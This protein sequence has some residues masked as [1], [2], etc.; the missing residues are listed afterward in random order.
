MR[1]KVVARAITAL[2]VSISA[3]RHLRDWRKQEGE[4]K[5]KQGR[6]RRRLG[7]LPFAT[8]RCCG[9]N[10]AYGRHTICFANSIFPHGH[11][12]LIWLISDH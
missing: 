9:N 12:A 3:I 11:T 4:M 10:K 7:R 6:T 5:R 2:R 1:A 8:K